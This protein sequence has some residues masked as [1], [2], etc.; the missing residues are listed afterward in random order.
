[1]RG[2]VANS[3]PGRRSVNRRSVKMLPAMLSAVVVVLL[4]LLLPGLLSA[5]EEIAGGGVFNYTRVLKGKGGQYQLDLM[6]SPS[7]PTAGDP[8]N[9]GVGVKRLLETPDP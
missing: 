5:H 3:V 7:L 2:V 6:Y 9:I 1:M 4:T 8:A